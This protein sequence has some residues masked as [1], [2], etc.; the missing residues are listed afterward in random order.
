MRTSWRRQSLATPGHEPRLKV[1]RNSQFVDRI[2]PRPTDP[3]AAWHV[4]GAACDSCRNSCR[5][6][7]SSRADIP[8]R[9]VTASVCEAFER[10]MARRCSASFTAATCRARAVPKPAPDSTSKASRIHDATR[11]RTVPSLPVL[12]LCPL[13]FV[14]TTHH[15]RD[16]FFSRSTP[17]SASTASMKRA[18]ECFEG[19]A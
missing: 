13:T 5:Y 3:T 9:R 17:S 2:I 8:S 7:V 15:Y 18:L 4:V 10:A 11:F 1:D 19:R 6:G 14:L 16:R 12:V